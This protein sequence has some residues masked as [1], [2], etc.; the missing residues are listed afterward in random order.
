MRTGW[1]TLLAVAAG[2]FSV[3]VANAQGLPQPMP[4]Q[5]PQSAIQQ[6]TPN[7]AQP[8]TGV[9]Q[10]QGCGT[11]GCGQAVAAPIAAAPVHAAPAAPS[12]VHRLLNPLTIGPGCGGRIGH[13]CWAAD[14]TVIFG[15]ARQFFTPGDKC[16]PRCG[17]NPWDNCSYFSYLDR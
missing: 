8:G 2:V 17:V 6:A 10:T 3:S 9:Q 13:A 7:Q 14:R 12:L 15:S 5:L 16:G 11:G 1:R 4:G